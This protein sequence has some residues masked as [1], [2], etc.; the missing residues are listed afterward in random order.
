VSDDRT[1][2]AIHAEL[3]PARIEADLITPVE[4]IADAEEAGRG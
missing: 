2:R 1:D 4:G 3:L